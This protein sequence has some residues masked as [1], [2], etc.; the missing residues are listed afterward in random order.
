MGERSDQ[1][2]PHDCELGSQELGK[3]V[4][5][6]AKS[7]HQGAPG[8]ES[9]LPGRPCDQEDKAHEITDGLSSGASTR[10]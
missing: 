4:S 1:T 5:G 3:I 9:H 2:G 10:H 8:L 6:D 7:R